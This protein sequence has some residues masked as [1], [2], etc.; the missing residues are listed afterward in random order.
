MRMC[1]GVVTGVAGG[2]WARWGWERE[3]GG[4]EGEGSAAEH[5]TA[6]G[7]APAAALG[8]RERAESKERTRGPKRMAV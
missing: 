2:V 4:D 5:V 7:G 6:V 1:P 3:V 8:T